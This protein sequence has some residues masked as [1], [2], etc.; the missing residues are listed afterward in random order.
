MPLQGGGEIHHKTEF[1]FICFPV[2][3]RV[4]D[5]QDSNMWRHQWPWPVAALLVMNDGPTEGDFCRYGRI[6]WFRT[7]NT[8]VWNI[9]RFVEPIYCITNP[10]SHLLVHCHWC[11]SGKLWAWNYKVSSAFRVVFRYW[12]LHVSHSIEMTNITFLIC[13]FNTSI[14]L[15]S[16]LRHPLRP[17]CGATVY[18]MSNSFLTKMS[19]ENVWLQGDKLSL[20]DTCWSHG[21]LSFLVLGDSHTSS[22]WKNCP[23][24]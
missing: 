18:Y 7:V 19:Y 1:M 17:V 11:S 6:C 15:K 8:T 24:S 14:F 10:Q 12:A 4:Q 9:G 5:N 20:N 22:F 2:T 23:A 13:I 16:T 21:W 3:G